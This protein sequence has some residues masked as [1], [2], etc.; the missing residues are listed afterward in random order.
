[1]GPTSGASCGPFGSRAPT[2]PRSCS[3]SSTTTP[4]SSA[5]W[6]WHGDEDPSG[7]G[8]VMRIRD[9]RDG[10]AAALMQLFY[11]TVHRINAA[12]YTTRQLEAWAPAD[13]MDVERWRARFAAKKPLVAVDGELPVGFAELE[14][15]GHIDA[16]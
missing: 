1:M 14:A 3:T 8:M 15:D 2:L 10:D 4:I 6:A 16:F 12:H 9:Y 11:D 7:R 5:R 13:G